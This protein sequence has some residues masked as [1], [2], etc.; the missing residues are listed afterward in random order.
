MSMNKLALNGGTPIFKKKI[1]YSQHVIDES[2]VTAVTDALHS[3]WLAGRSDVVREFEE[4]IAAYTGYKH[5]IA[6]NS[7][8]SG[9]YLAM[10]MLNKDGRLNGQAVTVP[11][12]TF[13]A[14]MNA[15]LL[16]GFKVKI[17][18]VDSDTYILSDGES[19]SI[20]VSYAGYPVSQQP[21]VVIDAAHE[22][23]RHMGNT[24]PD[25]LAVISTHAIKPLT[26]GEGGVVFAN[27]KATADLIRELSD[28]G[29]MGML[30]GH[31]FRMSSIQAALGLSQL[32]RA[33]EMFAI[34]REIA[35]I[36]R[37]RLKDVSGVKLQKNH[38][39]HSNHIF[40]VILNG[41]FNRD[42]F[43]DALLAEGVRTQ[44]HYQPLHLLKNRHVESARIT[45]SGKYPVAES[46]WQRGLSLPVHNAMT[47]K[48]ARMVMD[49]FEKVME[50]L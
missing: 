22:L 48:E 35:S 39:N 4:R 11:S 27:N 14:T 26:T 34:R 1:N 25:G 30:Y 31:N 20:P 12:L 15:P 10:L 32:E 28:H 44:I 43:R 40:P 33:D 18:D 9:L 3:D 42:S 50:L 13:I 21:H 41:L 24:G 7:A 37:D 5:A 2:D 19:W 45:V 17:K 36:Y 29:N 23:N 46:M 6:V 16:A 8:T 47:L 38:A 49:A